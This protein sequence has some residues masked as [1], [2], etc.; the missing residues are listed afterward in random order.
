M[1]IEIVITL[2]IASFICGYVAYP[3]LKR[4]S[5]EKGKVSWRE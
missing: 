5:E 2:C 1:E 3:I 4:Y